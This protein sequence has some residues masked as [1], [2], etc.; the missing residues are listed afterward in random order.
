MEFDALWLYGG[1]AVHKRMLKYGDRLTK[2]AVPR[3]LDI[4]AIE[5]LQSSIDIAPVLTADLIRS[6]RI[7]KKR[8]PGVTIRLITYGTD[9]AEYQHAGVGPSGALRPGPLTRKK[10]GT[11]DGAAGSK[12]LSRPF[13]RLAPQIERFVKAQFLKELRGAGKGT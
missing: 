5:I 4:A 7:V 3:A 1:D 12:W 9:Y 6:A 8:E 13:N 2:R 11:V 10:P